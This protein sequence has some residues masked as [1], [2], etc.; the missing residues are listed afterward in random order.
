MPRGQKESQ[1]CRRTVSANTSGCRLNVG[2]CRPFAKSSLRRVVM[3]LRKE[4][5]TTINSKRSRRRIIS[6]TCCC[7]INNGTRAGNRILG[8]WGEG[9]QRCGGG[10]KGGGGGEKEL[11]GGPSGVR[12]G[13]SRLKKVSL[14]I[15]RRQTMKKAGGYLTIR[16]VKASLPAR[17][18][19][20]EQRGS[21]SPRVR[22]RQK[23]NGTDW[24]WSELEKKMEGTGGR[25]GGKKE[26][27][28]GS[29]AAGLPTIQEV[30]RSREQ[31]K[32]EG[33]A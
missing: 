9:D 13:G 8:S 19:A 26:W 23:K 28:S 29:R 7:A 11:H 30:F 20:Q 10:K 24:G 15:N 32:N 14:R 25:R 4:N 5:S 2:I 6:D 18:Q 31:T 17:S 22:W 1:I 3:L 21:M 16:R 12:R 27:T 33:E